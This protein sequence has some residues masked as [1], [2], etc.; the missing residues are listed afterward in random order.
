MRMW[1]QSL[2]SL[3]KL[4]IQNCHEPCYKLQI[5]LRSAELW[6]RLAAA[7]PICLLACELPYATK[8]TDRQRKKKRK[9]CVL[10]G[11]VTLG[12]TSSQVAKNMLWFKL[13]PKTTI[14]AVV[15]RVGE[16]PKWDWEIRDK[17]G[18]VGKYAYIL[19]YIIVFE[20]FAMCLDI[21]FSQ[22]DKFLHIC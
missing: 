15:Y 13:T 4:R 18:L 12:R 9:W 21:I 6:R 3:S 1:V 16:G 14:I 2:A 8:K 22:K 10:I 5:Q 19:L 20:Y 11:R 17:R 7:A